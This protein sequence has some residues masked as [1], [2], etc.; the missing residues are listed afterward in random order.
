MREIKL[1]ALIDIHQY[2]SILSAQI[3]KFY[4]YIKKIIQC[5]E[6]IFSFALNF[7]ACSSGIV[8]IVVET[9]RKS[10]KEGSLRE[11]SKVW[12]KETFVFYL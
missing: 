5:T 3:T 8:V 11:R 1:H 12:K 2:V 7:R 4:F 9:S 10:E 6:V